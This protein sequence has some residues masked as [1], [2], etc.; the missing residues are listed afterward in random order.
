MLIELADAWELDA[1]MRLA[2]VINALIALPVRFQ[3]VTWMNF[4]GG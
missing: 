3:R 1:K 2:V 4:L